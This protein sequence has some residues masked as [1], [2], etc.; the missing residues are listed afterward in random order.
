MGRGPITATKALL[1]AL[2]AGTL[3]AQL[4]Y[5]PTLSGQLAEDNPE[6]TWLRWP[7]LGVVIVG[8]TIAQVALIA[9]WSLLTMTA[10]DAV[11]VEGAF[12]W[13]D[14]IIAA[15]VIDSILTAGINGFLSFQVHAN[16]PSLMLFLLALTVCGATFALLMAVMRGLLR[17]AST[18]HGELSEVI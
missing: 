18:F 16:P 6:L 1:A 11:F 17:K 2:L 15:A 3:A 7:L 14:V 9:V 13:V 5:F 8:I 4:W 12:R 10:R